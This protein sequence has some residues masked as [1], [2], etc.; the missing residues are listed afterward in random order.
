MK[1]VELMK[2]SFRID[3][4]QPVFLHHTHRHNYRIGCGSYVC[5]CIISRLLIGFCFFGIFM[6]RL[7]LL[8]IRNDLR[9]KEVKKK[10]NNL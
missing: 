9:E 5:I 3:N 2:E 6:L 1:P 4:K 8:H 10:N 7:P